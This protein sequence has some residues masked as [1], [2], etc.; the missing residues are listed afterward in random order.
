MRYQPVF[1][2]LAQSAATAAAMAINEGSA[3]QDIDYSKLRDQLLTDG[4]KLE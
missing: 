3:V 4:Q 2:I 1:M